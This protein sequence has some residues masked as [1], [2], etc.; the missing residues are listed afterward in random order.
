MRMGM[1]EKTTFVAELRRDNELRWAPYVS[2]EDD[3]VVAIGSW[4]GKGGPGTGWR[5][6]L[7]RDCLKPG[8]SWTMVMALDDGKA[9]EHERVGQT[10]DVALGSRTV[11]G[12]QW[13]GNPA[14]HVTTT[15]TLTR[16]TRTRTTP[17]FNPHRLRVKKG[18]GYHLWVP[19][20]CRAHY[21]AQSLTKY[22]TKN[23]TKNTKQ[24]S[25]ALLDGIPPNCNL[26]LFTHQVRQ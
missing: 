26:R 2:L 1:F 13:R 25:A 20:Y 12:R 3:S 16:T 19:M 18:N 11:V 6:W 9:E 23:K 10:G 5:S 22:K 7:D 24:I 8:E 14:G 4:G 21:D 17:G 15:R